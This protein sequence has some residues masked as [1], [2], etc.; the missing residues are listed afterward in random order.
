MSQS[1]SRQT[2]FKENRSRRPN[3]ENI[4]T[5]AIYKLHCKVSHSIVASLWGQHFPRIQNKAATLFNADTY[6][7]VQ[8][9][10]TI[11]L[12]RALHALLCVSVLISVALLWCIDRTSVAFF[13]RRLKNIALIFRTALKC[14]APYRGAPH[15]TVTLGLG[16]AHIRVWH[17]T[18]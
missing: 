8:H 9:P 3:C 14:A 1:K 10:N 12:I 17:F 6:I 18:M 4:E 11:L 13:F 2:R 15:H 5:E 16:F 7:G